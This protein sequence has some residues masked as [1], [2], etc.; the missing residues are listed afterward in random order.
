MPLKQRL[1]LQ[2]KKR[3]SN[4]II[5]PAIKPSRSVAAKYRKD[6]NVLINLMA[7]D[8][9]QIIS[10][11]RTN[12]R[13]FV[14]DAS[15]GLLLRD[16]MNGIK[17][18]YRDITAPA[19]GIATTAVVGEAA[20]NSQKF[21]KGIERVTGGISIGRIIGNE[22]LN[23]VL[24]TQI[25]ANVDLIQSIPDEYFKK[26]SNAVYQ[27]VSRGDTVGSLTKQIQAIT[28]TTRSRAKLIARDQTSK[29]NALITQN[30]QEALGVEEYIWQTSADGRVRKTHRDNNGKTF[31]WDKPDPVTGHPGEDIQCRCVARAVINL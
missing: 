8:M 6:M 5:A 31:R 29:T 14:V 16:L 1:I 17:K 13:E 28:R 23:D 19:T 27:G 25:A 26:I 10:F 24:Q 9:I 3:R 7:T 20:S 30:R 15:F 2:R 4:V 12:Q 22:G 18:K 21:D 11:L